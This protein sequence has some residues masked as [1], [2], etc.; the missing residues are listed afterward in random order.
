MIRNL[1][2]I[3]GILVILGYFVRILVVWYRVRKMFLDDQSGFE[4]AKDI[5]SDYDGI[6]VVESKEVSISRYQIN[7]NVIRLTSRDY[8]GK[9]IF[10][11]G[12]ASL[13]AGYSLI[14]N[15]HNRYMDI[16]GKVFRSIDYVNK[17]SL[18]AIVI[19]V[20]T[21]T[22]GDARIGAVLLGILLVYQYLRVQVDSLNTTYVE[23]QMR[24][25]EFD[26]LKRVRDCFLELSRVSFVV[27]LIF[28]LREFVIIFNI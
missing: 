10:S 26:S 9:S 14:R 5:C 24:E 6:H 17:S 27:T 2:L 4:M 3:V 11:L 19:S 21:N 13:L 18:V 1:L 25:E 23:E 22:V 20:L 8:E 7:R 15:D 16:Y 28:L 12:I